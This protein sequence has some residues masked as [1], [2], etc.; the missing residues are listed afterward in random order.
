LSFAAAQREILPSMV[1]PT[2]YDLT[3][4]PD[5]AELVFKGVV[6]IEV[7]VVQPTESIVLNAKGLVFD[8]VSLDGAPANSITLDEKLTRATFGFANQVSPGIHQL[9][10]EYHGPILKSTFGFFAMEYDTPEGKEAIV[11]TNF[12][13][14]GARMLLPCW[15]EPAVKATFTMAVDAP[16]NRTAIS[17][18]P[19]EK[20]TAAGD[21]QRVHFATTPK[22]STYL[23]FA[24]IGDYERVHRTV[25]KTDVGIVVKRGDLPRAGYALDEACSLLRYYNDY[26]GMPFALPKLD[27][28]AA[29]GKI[30]GG[31][32]ENWG[33]IFYSQDQLLFDPKTSTERDRQ[34]VFLVVSHEMAHQWFGDLVTMGWW[35][36]LWLNEGFARWMQTHAADSL[37]PEWR[38]GLQ[39][40]SIAESGKR[41]DSKPSTHPVIQPVSS[42]EQAAQAFDDITYDKG[43]SIVTML[44]AYIGGDIFREGVR[45]YMRLYAYG[46]TANDDLWSQMQK[47]AK[48]PIIQIANDFTRQP[49]LPLIKVTGTKDSSELNL[50]RFYEDRSSQPDPKQSWHLPVGIASPGQRDQ[51]VLLSAR[52]KLGAPFPLVNVGARSYTRVLYSPAQ[53]QAVVARLPKLAAADQLNLANDLWALGQAGYVSASDLFDY[54][55]ALPVNADAIVWSRVCELLLEIDRYYGK[56]PEREAFRQF[57]RTVL[58]PVLSRLGES[59]RPGEDAALTSL[60]SDLWFAQARFGDGDAVRRANEI[61]SSQTGSQAERRTALEIVG[62]TA[63]EKTFAALLDKARATADP[64]DRSHILQALAAAPDPEETKHFI[65][66]ALSSTAPA[67]TAPMLIR[68]AA[69]ANPDAVWTALAEHFDDPNL[70]IDELVRGRIISG[71]AAQSGELSRIDDIQRYADKHLPA[72]TRQDVD[73]AVASIRLNR[74]VRDKAIPQIDAWIQAH[75]SK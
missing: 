67:G 8:Q 62:A 43:A 70:P 15:D 29:P 20:T 3:I 7:K 19:V 30:Y 64:L 23:L 68:A 49:G 57:A 51:A 53:I 74:R 60:R 17:N 33:A 45:R 71:V 66:V 38:T 56:S 13:P 54:L 14:T 2:H 35:D 47:V 4:T 63:D 9:A 5:P 50:S 44:E 52:H 42:A 41:A 18:M 75:R 22:M 73:A 26:F 65:E 27:L 28:I 11:A 16:K 61:Y 39:A 72:D 21:L 34:L 32:M 55:I 6:R 48:K 1:V 36:N 37:H 58:E 10:I 24:T 12:E 59:G 40:Q 46:N 25:G 31:S 69:P